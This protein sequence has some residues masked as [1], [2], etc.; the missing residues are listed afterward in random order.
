MAITVKERYGRRL[1]GGKAEL[2]YLV[3][4]TTDAGDARAAVISGSTPA[5]ATY[6]GL[7]RDAFGIE[8]EEI[9]GVAGG[10]YEARVPYS[11]TGSTP[12]FKPILKAGTQRF[13]LAT[14]G[15]SQ[16]ITQS[17]S[18]SASTAIADYQ[19]TGG[20]APDFAKAI[21]VNF[22]GSINGV[23]I[24]LRQFRFRITR[25]IA[26]AS[27]TQ[28]LLEN[29]YAVTGTTNNASFAPTIQGAQKITFAA[30]ECVLEG[31]DGGPRGD[32]VWEFTFDFWAVPNVAALT[33]VTGAATVAKKGSEY[34][35]TY[36][37][38]VALADPPML[39][40]KTVAGYVEK[41]IAD[42]DFSLLG[43]A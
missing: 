41:V 38:P 18:T 43:I 4:G 21:G 15:A 31:V 1:D 30:G 27:V 25:A 33:P 40:H 12:T 13:E 34:V 5:P 32:G 23:D 42:G 37:V 20:D 22:D 16:H 3:K 36:N 17:I 26:E 14:G 6:E 39:T 9:A 11:Q 24:P 2:V 8:V 29:L 19:D 10:A 28:T 35:W 7:D